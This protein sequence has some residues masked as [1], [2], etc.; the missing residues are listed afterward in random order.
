[1]G[2]G[3][4]KRE[5]DV[6]VNDSYS[7]PPSTSSTAPVRSCNAGLASMTRSTRV[8]AK[9]QDFVGRGGATK[10]CRRRPQEGGDGAQS[11]T[12]RGV[13][14]GSRKGFA[15]AYSEGG[16][17]VGTIRGISCKAGVHC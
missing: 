15:K 4:G 1:V 5:S 10:R 7:L 2:S 9:S 17:G 6:G 12:T 11:A 3:R 14:G 13:P 16:K 8:P